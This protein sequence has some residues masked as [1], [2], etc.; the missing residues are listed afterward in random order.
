MPARGPRELIGG[1]I[2]SWA[3]T[4]RYFEPVLGST[5]WC[6]EVEHDSG[7]GGRSGG[8]ARADPPDLRCQIKSVGHK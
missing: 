1:G 3:D 5:Q 4:A 7:V 6:L 8:I 2:G